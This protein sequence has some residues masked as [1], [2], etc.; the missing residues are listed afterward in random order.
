M[1][2]LQGTISYPEQKWGKPEERAVRNTPLIDFVEDLAGVGA[3]GLEL[4]GHHLDDLDESDV[5]ALAQ[6]I[7]ETGQSVE[8]L[9]P[10]WD[11]ASSGEAV[12]NSLEDARRYLG[13]KDVFECRLIRVFVG[14]VGSAEATGEHW[15]RA[16]DGLSRLARMYEG[17]GVTFVVETH[18]NQ[19][20]D[21]PESC[22]KLMKELGEGSIRLNYQNMDGPAA[23]ELGR[24]Y[25]W[26]SH[27][28]VSRTQKWQDRSADVVR[29][30][31]KRGYDGTVTV[32]FCTNS[33][34]GEDEEFDRAKAIEGMKGDIACLRSAAG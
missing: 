11:F 19:L 24:L 4:W 32:E 18:S 2:F 5:E 15:E 22:L 29:E 26:V 16:L 13:L 6:K 23:D 3:D 30:L 34:P 12:E 7:T 20:P 28:H 27:C 8:V 17:S 21:S 10:Y 33:L 25:E 14:G 1:R 31:A 9:G